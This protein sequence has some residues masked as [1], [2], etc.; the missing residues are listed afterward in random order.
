MIIDLLFFL[1]ISFNLFIGIYLIFKLK[2]RSEKLHTHLLGLYFIVH[3][4]CFSFYLI[5]KYELII[6][7]PYLYKIPAPITYLIAPLS[8]FHVCSL[9]FNKKSF[10]AFDAIHLLPFIIF[11]ISYLPFYLMPLNEKKNYLELVFLNFNLTFTDDIGLVPEHI[12][13]AGRIIHPLIYIVL[14]W[15]I[16][17]SK[18]GRNFKVVNNK[19]YA[20]VFNLT[21]MQ[22]FFSIGLTSIIIFSFLFPI[23]FDYQIFEYLPTIFTIIFFFGISVYLIWNQDILIKLK[24]FSFTEKIKYDNKELNIN[25]LTMK[26]RDNLYFTNQSLNISSLSKLLEINQ[27]D[28]SRIINNTYS[29]YNMW[30]NEIRIKYSIDLIKEGYLEKYSVEALAEKSGFKSK[31]TFYRSFKR[32]TNTTPI[33]FGND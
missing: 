10:K 3:A 22:T 24:Y 19:L 14:Q 7:V 17:A 12:N 13:S 21:M 11:L 15:I 26:V 31:N 8:Y 6:Y 32:Y 33:N 27:N 9:V 28:L 29:N 30:I 20:W 18:S 5:I 25:Y 1:I 23:S 2:P 4:F 16:I